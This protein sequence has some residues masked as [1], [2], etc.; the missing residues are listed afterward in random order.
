VAVTTKDVRKGRFANMMLR[1]DSEAYQCRYAVVEVEAKMPLVELVGLE[2]SRAR[3]TMP[4]M[5]TR[6]P[7]RSKL[8][9]R[10]RRGVWMKGTGNNMIAMVFGMLKPRATALWPW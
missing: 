10:R 3:D 2:R 1:V 8:V 6:A 7:S 4:V 9:R 5:R